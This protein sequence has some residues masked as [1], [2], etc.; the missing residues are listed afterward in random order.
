MLKKRIM[1]EK[2]E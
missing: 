1:T 2:I